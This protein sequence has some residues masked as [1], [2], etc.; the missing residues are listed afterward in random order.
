MTTLKYLS[1]FWRTLEI[2]L[3]DCEIILDLKWSKNCVIVATNVAA[4]ATIFWITGTKHYVPVVTLST[5]DNT[6][7]FEQLK[8]GFKKS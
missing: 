8:S 2:T 6:K 7:M 4:Q 1:N 5:Q 3:T